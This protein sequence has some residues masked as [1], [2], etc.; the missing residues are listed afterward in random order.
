MIMLEVRLCLNQVN[1]NRVSVVYHITCYISVK[2]EANIF[3]GDVRIV[4][5]MEGDFSMQI[6]KL[7]YSYADSYISLKIY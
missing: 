4:M 1:R 3:V 2:C 6:Q 5:M 7:E